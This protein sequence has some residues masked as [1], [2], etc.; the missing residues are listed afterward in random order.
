MNCRGAGKPTTV[1]ELRDL[2]RQLAPSIVC[3]VE[4]QIEGSRVENMVG[5]LNFN[6]SF[7]VSSSGRSGG[8]GIFWNEEIKLEVL[9]YSKYHIDALV[10]ELFDIQTRVTFVYG[11]D[12]VSEQ[13]NTWDTLKGIVGSLN[14]PWVVLGD[15]NE[16]LHGHEHDGVG[17]RSQA[18]MD[19]FRDALDTYGLSDIGYTGTDWTFEK[20]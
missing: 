2:T 16:V 18:Q 4:T 8:L 3:I 9:G 13:Y 17:M 14:L 7:A 19:G 12:Q 20:R 5:S 15:F 11:E 6:K 10:G 1:R